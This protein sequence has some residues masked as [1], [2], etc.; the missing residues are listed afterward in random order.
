MERPSAKQQVTEG[1]GVF[2]GLRIRVW[3]PGGVEVVV[4][5]LGAVLAFSQD[6]STR[7]KP[8]IECVLTRHW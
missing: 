3:G 4:F 5:A 1:G 8:M 2:W 6:D 7:I